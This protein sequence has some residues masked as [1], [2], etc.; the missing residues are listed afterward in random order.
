MREERW[1]GVCTH[2]YMYDMCVQEGSGKDN[3]HMGAWSSA[4]LLGRRLE[5]VSVAVICIGEH[6]FA[7]IKPFCGN[8]QEIID[9]EKNLSHSF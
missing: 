2:V 5:R 4:L 9:G 1:H 8:T 7:E 3:L 6:R